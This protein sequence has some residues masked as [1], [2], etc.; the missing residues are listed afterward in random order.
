MIRTVA[1]VGS[2]LIGTSVGLAL[3]RRGVRV[4]VMDADES[5][6]RVAAARGAGICGRPPEPVDLAVLAVPPARITQVLAEQQHQKLA[7]AYTDVA[8]VKSATAQAV[9][10][11]APHRPSYVGGH[12]MAGS[13]CSG[14]L[15]AGADLFQGRAWLLTPGTETSHAA[16][17]RVLAAV[18]LCG[19]VPVVME[20]QAHDRAVALVSHAPHLVAVLMAARLT[21]AP[22]ESLALAGQGLRDVIRIAGGDRALWSDIVTSNAPALA[23]VLGELAKDLEALTRA[24]R[25][26]EVHGPGTDSAREAIAQLLFRGRTGWECVHEPEHTSGQVTLSIPLTD[27]LG[28]VDRLVS[29]ARESGIGTDSIR[30]RWSQTSSRLSACLAT[31]PLAAPDVR[32]RLTDSGWQVSVEPATPSL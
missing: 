26:L 11:S 12:P 5:A 28:E 16:L 6:A 3:S 30:L 10:R 27:R 14:P 23:E 22:R 31:A 25:E 8:S 9:A 18:A 19:A 1:V 15:A 20:P 17:N 4:H 2:G 21:G 29:A 24:L 13:Q 32:R 7:R